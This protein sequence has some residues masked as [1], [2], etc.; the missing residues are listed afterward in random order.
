MCVDSG[1]TATMNGSATANN[2]SDPSQTA[3]FCYGTAISFSNNMCFIGTV[4]SATPTPTG[5]LATLVSASLTGLQPGTVYFYVLL[6]DYGAGGLVSFPYAFITA[7]VPV[8]TS[9]AATAVTGTTVT[10][11]GLAT[12]ND[13][14]TGAATV[15]FCYGATNAVTSVNGST[16]SGG[17]LAAATPSTATGFLPTA[18]TSNLTGL[19]TGST[20]YFV[21]VVNNA[22]GF[23]VSSPTAV[24][25]AGPR[26]R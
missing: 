17:I 14:G 23:V 8:A 7:G 25:T 24:V 10:L 3:T 4:F 13:N 16:C 18:E 6:V 15:F 19:S 26:D 2:G 20:Y 5:S 12:A 11:N 9:S 22:D 1:P 21:L